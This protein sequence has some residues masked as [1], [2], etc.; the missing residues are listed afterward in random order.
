LRGVGLLDGQGPDMSVQG[1]I[2]YI[3]PGAPATRRPAQGD[4][5]FLRPEI[6]FTPRWYREAL[7]IDFSRRWHTDVRHRRDTVLAMRRELRRRFP[8]TCIG[9]IDKPEA[10]LDLLTGVFGAGTVAGIFGLPLVYYPDNWPNV[11]HAYRTREQLAL[12]RPPDLDRNAAFQDLLR[13]STRSRQ[14]RGKSSASSIGREFSTMP[15]AAGAGP[16]PRPV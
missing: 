12:I 16:V 10:P 15:A 5:P 7:G 4:E 2:S 14:W 3:A 8:G 13:R 9:G 6:G 1:L 11:A